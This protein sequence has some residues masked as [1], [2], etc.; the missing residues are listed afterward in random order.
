VDGVK[1][2]E[3]ER[4]AKEQERIAKMETLAEVEPLK[5]LLDGR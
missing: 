5:K 1:T 2:E 3:Q 4:V